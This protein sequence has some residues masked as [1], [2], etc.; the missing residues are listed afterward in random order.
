MSSATVT[1]H[2]SATV[3]AYGSATVRAYGSA[4]VRAYDS[5]T[6]RAYGSATVRA[7]SHVAVHLHSGRATIQGGILIDHTAIDL[8]DA[9]AWLAYNGATVKRGRATLYKAVLDDWTTGRG[10]EWTYKP[11]S[12]V[13]AKD[14]TTVAD[15]GGGLHL[16]V[17]PGHALKYCDAATRFVE[18]TVKAADVIPLGDKCKAPSAKCVREVDVAGRPIA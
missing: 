8:T 11:G 4:T 15:C 14:F 13:T 12:T 18:V 5:A 7:G 17:T 2:D 10:G 16:G 1:A 9:A 3:T 6:V